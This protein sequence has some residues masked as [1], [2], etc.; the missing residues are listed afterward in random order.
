[1]SCCKQILL[2][3]LIVIYAA[4]NGRAFTQV[5]QGQAL[6]DSLLQALSKTTEDTSKIY[7]LYKLAKAYSSDDSAIAFKYARECLQLSKQRNWHKGS[8]FAYL[9]M[10]QINNEV[11]NYTAAIECSKNAY[12]IFS[13]QQEK[14]LMGQ[15][16]IETGVA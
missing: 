13:R 1:M 9:A 7:L 15:A 8:G 14:K 10:A 16:L 6:R 4:L 12:I 11:T 3:L 5:L 2:L